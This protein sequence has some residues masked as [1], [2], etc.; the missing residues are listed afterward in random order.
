MPDEE[1]IHCPCCGSTRVL[2]FTGHDG[3]HGVCLA[4]GC[5]SD[6]GLGPDDL[7]PWAVSAHE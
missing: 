5:D 6:G 1:V 4:C 7:H 2:A 3:F